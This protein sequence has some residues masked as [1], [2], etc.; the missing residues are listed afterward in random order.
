MEMSPRNITSS[1]STKP[2]R[3]ATGAAFR[4]MRGGTWASMII[5]TR[6][7]A[8]RANCASSMPRLLPDALNSTMLPTAPTMQSAMNSGPSRCSA[9]NSCAV[10]VRVRCVREDSN[11]SRLIRRSLGGC[12]SDRRQGRSGF[13]LRL[14]LRF[15]LGE[16]VWRHQIGIQDAAGDWRG[17]R[18]T[19][20]WRV[21]DDDCHCDLERFGRSKRDEQRVI[22]QMLGKLGVFAHFL[23]DTDGEHL[24][25]TALA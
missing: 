16:L 7:S 22:A 4:M 6:P 3:Y 1:S 2:S 23:V 10:P 14:A 5:A 20:A 8:K 25:R 9:N 12:R 13:F 21:L 11:A 15:R 17:P 19:A 18:G 24:R